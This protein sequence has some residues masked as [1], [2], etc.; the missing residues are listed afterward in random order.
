MASGSVVSRNTD[1]SMIRVVEDDEQSEDNYLRRLEGG[2]SQSA[3][4][5]NLNRPYSTT[6]KDA[7]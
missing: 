3:Y 4:S 7:I 5:K 1:T 6:Q 2:A